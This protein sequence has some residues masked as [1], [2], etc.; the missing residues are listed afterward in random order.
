MIKKHQIALIGV[1]ESYLET[2]L[3][4]HAPSAIQAM[5][6]V[7]TDGKYEEVNIIAAEAI[8]E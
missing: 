3:R 2:L 5:K 4:D 8:S 1:N 6:S 7:K